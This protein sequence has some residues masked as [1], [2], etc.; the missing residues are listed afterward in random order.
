VSP[1]QR[2]LT[3]RRRIERWLHRL[4]QVGLRALVVLRRALRQYGDTEAS[5]AAAALA[6][7][8]FFSLFPL[9]LLLVAAATYL[10]HLGNEEGFQEA[11]DFIGRLLPVSQELIVS[12][13]RV[14]VRLRGAF[15]PLS[16]LT[17]LWSA[18]SAFTVLSHHINRAWVDAK[19]RSYLGKRLVALVMVAIL[20]ML[21]FLSLG[22]A[23]LVGYLPRLESTNPQIQ[24]LERTVRSA[25]VR[26]LPPLITMVLFLGLFRWIPTESVSWR[27]AATGALAATVG[28][29]LGKQLFAWV[30]RQGLLNYST[31]YGSLSSVAL[32]LF[33]A[34]V[35]ASIVLFGAHVAAA[36]DDHRRHGQSHSP[37][38]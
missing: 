9:A 37:K 10:W 22:S 26:L 38:S 6:Y 19:P 15:T 27:A 7:Y 18:S 35:A 33:W 34:Y 29:E 16:A 36:V 8:L 13:L 30:L 21:L 23:T 5:Q 24:A 25:L 12:N 14:V 3:A 4:A 31:V 1:E 2:A 32:L 17:T 11:V 28:L 20:I